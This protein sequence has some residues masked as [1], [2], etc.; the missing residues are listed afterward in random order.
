MFGA[1]LPQAPAADSTHDWWILGTPAPW[2]RPPSRAP[3]MSFTAA[4]LR[5]SLRTWQHGDW[6]ADQPV[7]ESKPAGSSFSHHWF[8]T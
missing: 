5:S 6:S 1:E 4:K 2:G 8:K 3:W 7:F